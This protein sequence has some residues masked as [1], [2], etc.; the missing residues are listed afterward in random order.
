MARE[1]LQIEL[2]E[3]LRQACAGNSEV[4]RNR[5]RVNSNGA[6][7]YVDLSVVKL[8][9]PEDLR[10]L[11]LVSFCPTPSQPYDAGTATSAQGTNAEDGERFEQLERALKFMRET[12]QTT[13]EDLETANEELESTVE[14]LQSTNEELQSTN[15]ELE[16]SKEEMQSLNEELTTVNAE[17]QSKVEDL[18]QSS[19]DMQNLLNSTKIAT[20]FLDNE[21][22]IKRFTDRARDL[23]M[24]RQE[25]VGRPISELASKLQ[26]EDL[27]ADCRN[28]LK[29]LVFMEAEVST[30]DGVIYLMRIMPYRTATNAIDGLVLTFVDIS[31]LKQVETDLRHMSEVFREGADPAIIVN[32]KGE[33]LD[34]NDE[35]VRAYGYARDDLL[36][37]PVRKIIP[38]ERGDE[39]E[40]L[41][42]RCRDG[43]A[44][45]DV[46]WSLLNR[47]GDEAAVLL[48][49][50]VLTGETGEVDAMAFIA[51]QFNGK[52]PT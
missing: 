12:H 35:A 8:D 37:Q 21:L 51:R 46:S 20:L 45:R 18:S 11:L 38:P 22:K 27:G 25:D 1:G 10:D 9:E 39:V 2:V 17:L 32:L 16:T 47:S 36:G 44:I 15:E 5:V 29:T 6:S 48:N 26:H 4:A 41:I 49:L 3:A 13:L 42:N 40:T 14:E 19:N 7:T 50:T 23:V 31:R 33:I 30:S 43:E 28:V 52:E 24:L 34:L